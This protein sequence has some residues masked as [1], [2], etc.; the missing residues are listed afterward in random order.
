MKQRTHL[1]VAMSNLVNRKFL[2]EELHHYGINSTYDEYLQFKGFAAF[3]VRQK[4]ASWVLNNSKKL[5]QAVGDNF[6]AKLSTP[7]GF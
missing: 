2:I 5:I 7:N 4:E 1:Q 3:A 6:D